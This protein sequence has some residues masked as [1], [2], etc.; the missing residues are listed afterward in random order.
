MF[1]EIAVLLNWLSLIIHFP[2]SHEW[3]IPDWEG[4]QARYEHCSFVSE[5]DPESLWVFGGAEQSANRNCVQVL[6]T[7]GNSFSVFWVDSDKGIYY[8]TVCSCSC[9]QT[10]LY[11]EQWKWRGR[12][13][14]RGRTTLTRRVWEINCLSSPVER[15]GPRLW[16]T[17]RCT[18]LTQVKLL[19]SFFL[20]THSHQELSIWPTR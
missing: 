7:T 11:G 19:Q 9:V 17:P 14:A 18:S 15:R 10:A 5:S 13:R 20:I 1:K 2:D 8:V 6:R 16:P 12:A 3:D 4:L